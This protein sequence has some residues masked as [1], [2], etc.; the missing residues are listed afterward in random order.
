M[1]RINILDPKYLSDQH[2]VAEYL[3]IMMLVGYV[4]KNPGLN[5]IPEEYCLGEG[6][7][8]FF[9]N[10]LKYLEERH[11]EIKCEMRNRGFKTNVTLE[12][13]EIGNAFKKRWKPSSSDKQI[14]KKRLIEKINKKPGFYRYYGKARNG[15]FWLR[16]IKNAT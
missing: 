13:G 5:R 14:I 7:I 3:E 9:K 1:V 8:L 10:K 12:M 2:L 16:M 4:K 11:E 6:H 15:R